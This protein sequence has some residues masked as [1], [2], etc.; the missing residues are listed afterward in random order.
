VLR[1]ATLPLPVHSEDELNRLLEAI[2]VADIR[3]LLRLR[4]SKSFVGSILSFSKVKLNKH[5]A[6]EAFK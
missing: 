1:A 4:C 5:K 2:L 6:V 3:T